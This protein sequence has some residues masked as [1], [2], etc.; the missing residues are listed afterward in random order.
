MWIINSYKYYQQ[1]FLKGCKIFENRS[2]AKSFLD[3]FKTCPPLESL[4]SLPSS[5]AFVII[6]TQFQ[7]IKI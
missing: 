6:H 5:V 2:S 3:D 4:K 7:V 1:V